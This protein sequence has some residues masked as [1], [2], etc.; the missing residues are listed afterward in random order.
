[1]LASLL[2]SVSGSWWASRATR[3]EPDW[4]LSSIVIDAS[5]SIAADASRTHE[6][7][8]AILGVLAAA[9]SIRLL[10][11]GSGRAEGSGGLRAHVTVGPG[12]LSA[13]P[14]ATDVL[15]LRL[16][17][18][19][20][21]AVPY[22]AAVPLASEASAAAL[23]AATRRALDHLEAMRRLERAG[24]AAILGALRAP[25]GPQRDDGA[26]A[27]GSAELAVRAFAVQR[28]AARRAP[29]ACAALCALLSAGDRE[30]AGPIERDL[31]LRAVG[32]LVTLGAQQ[33]VGPLIALA[34]HKDAAFVLQLAYA[35]G[36]I[37]GPQATGYLVAL[38]SGHTDPE[39]RAGA[40]AALE[41]LLARA[42]AAPG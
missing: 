32:A 20:G 18:R 21:D 40:G 28:A 6:I 35:I 25:L 38:G 42:A 30:D 5:P 36:A 24:D 10:P 12:T 13:A 41:E 23:A 39:V 14:A 3:A 15:R 2:C 17:E 11:E 26:G 33:A 8:A 7:Q 22:D 9:P 37:G 1:M 31:A 19:H 4:P 27:D 29:E 34:Q 16:T